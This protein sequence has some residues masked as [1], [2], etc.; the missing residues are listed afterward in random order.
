MPRHHPTGLSVEEAARLL[1][2]SP[3]TVRRL[4]HTGRLAG[5]KLGR[6]WVVW[7]P[8]EPPVAIVSARQARKNPPALSAHTTAAIRQRLREVGALLIEVGNHVTEARK[9]RGHL[10][11]TW[12]TPH[13]LRVTLAIGRES[14]TRGWSP[15]ALGVELPFW[16]AERA[17]W[18]TVLP[19][20]R[21]YEQIR[22]WCAPQLLRIAG[23][24]EV[25][26]AALC[27]VEA[28]L[29]VL[30]ETPS[31]QAPSS[32]AKGHHT[33]GTSMALHTS[34]VPPVR[35]AVPMA[36]EGATEEGTA[37]E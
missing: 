35:A 1:G 20:L 10:F 30:A 25:V 22:I 14:P 8:T 2:C 16:L 23:V 5:R 21:Q 24:S 11:L 28:A 31:D 19:L 26:L 7:F 18:R 9:G 4:L 6:E 27:R 13:A 17:R 29:R 33:E 36:G 32:R 34:G 37:Q 12:R 15:H 3:Q